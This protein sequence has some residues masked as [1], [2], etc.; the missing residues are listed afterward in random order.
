MTEN[1]LDTMADELTD[2]GDTVHL[3]E[4]EGFSDDDTRIL[5]LRLEPDDMT[6]MD[7]AGEGVWCGRL[8]WDDR[9]VNDYGWR[10]RPD[11]FDG[12]AEVIYRDRGDRMWWQVPDD[13]APGSEAHASLRR[14]I[15]DII[16]YGY[17]IAIIELLDGT[18]AYGRPIVRQVESLGGIEPFPDDAHM[19]EVVTAL[20]EQMDI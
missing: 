18:D 7:E 9:N 8:A 15:L 20:L 10:R 14:T 13:I 1:D 2:D 3:S 17:H 4:Y 16:E 6:I 11:G 5:R 19:L 12:R